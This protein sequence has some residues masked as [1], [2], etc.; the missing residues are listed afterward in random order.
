MNINKYLVTEERVNEADESEVMVNFLRDL[1]KVLQSYGVDPYFDDGALFM[2]IGKGDKKR[3]I[4]FDRQYPFT[5][6]TID[7]FIKD[8]KK[9]K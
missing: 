5:R 6:K 3:S 7:K 2:E 9:R 4:G 8:I 1:R